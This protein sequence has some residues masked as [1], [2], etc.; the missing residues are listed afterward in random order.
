MSTCIPLLH[1][2]MLIQY[3]PSL[4]KWPITNYP[5]IAAITYGRKA[6]AY[7]ALF[8]VWVTGLPVPRLV[9]SLVSLTTGL[10]V[11]PFPLFPVG[12]TG[13]LVP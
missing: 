11:S 13:L 6:H 12:V 5:G 2:T 1:A 9:V 4:P 7:D 3:I 8:P 10:D